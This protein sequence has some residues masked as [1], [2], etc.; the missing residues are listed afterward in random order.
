MKKVKKMIAFLLHD[1]L[2]LS[3]D[4]AGPLNQS[5]FHEGISNLTPEN[6][7]LLYRLACELAYKPDQEEFRSIN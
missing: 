1:L 7:L 2:Y 4:V 5:Q 6:I 3:E